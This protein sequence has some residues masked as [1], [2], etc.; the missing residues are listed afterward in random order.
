MSVNRKVTVRDGALTPTASHA[1]HA[2]GKPHP[3]DHGIRSDHEAAHSGSD[4]AD[5]GEREQ[6]AL[7]S[8]QR[9]TP[10]TTGNESTQ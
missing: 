2:K 7:E 10:N 5:V 3:G 8:E 4:S 1:E 9:H 6:R